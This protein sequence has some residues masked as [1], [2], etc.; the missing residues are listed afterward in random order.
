MAPAFAPIVLALALASCAAPPP[1]PPSPSPPPPPDP[2]V[3]QHQALKKLGFVEESEGWNLN[4]SGRVLFGIDEIT[5][6]KEGAAT[7]SEI[8]KV[9]LSVGI[10]RLTVE[11]HTDNTGTPAHNRILSQRRAEVVAATLSTYGFAL[12]NI[13]R[14][15]YGATRPFASNDT[16]AG[17]AQNRRAVLIVSSH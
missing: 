12:A 5:P 6:S 16:A 2:V 9:L 4:L 8:A 14:R 13:E 15:A 7:L 1:P 11:G 3:V 10:D 17:R